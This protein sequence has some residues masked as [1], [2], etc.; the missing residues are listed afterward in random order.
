MFSPLSDSGTVVRNLHQSM[1]LTADGNDRR[2]GDAFSSRAWRSSDV[3]N[4]W[5]LAMANQRQ[6]QTNQGQE[7]DNDSKTHEEKRRQTGENPSRQEPRRPDDPMRE[8]HKPND[9]M[10]EPPTRQPQPNPQRDDRQHGDEEKG[11]EP[12]ER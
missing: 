10:R 2:A 12:K 4:D 1:L 6:D 9:P 3:G 5:R 11:G 7:Q 8:P